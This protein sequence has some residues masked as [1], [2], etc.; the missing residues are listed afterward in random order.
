MTKP[1]V[2]FFISLLLL[3]SCLHRS[4]PVT[5]QMPPKVILTGLLTQNQLFD[6]IQAYQ[7][8]KDK[9]QPA[10]GAIKKLQSITKDVQLIVF[11]GTWCSDSE[12]EVPRFLKIMEL[13]K[14][15]HITFKLFGLDRSK[16]DPDGLAEK[17][18][19]EYVPTFIVLHNDQ[20]IG[21]IVETPIIS[22]EQD[23]VEI[24]A[25]VMEQNN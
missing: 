15:S 14:N 16:R 13:T 12:C 22:L 17:H 7:L 6:R 8:G 23:L 10:E 25:S 4:P 2:G 18:Q 9:Y 11:L 21:R 20:E 24:V 19:I 3:A 1:V 5:E